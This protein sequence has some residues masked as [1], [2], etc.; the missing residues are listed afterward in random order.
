[1]QICVMVQALTGIL[2]PVTYGP[3]TMRGSSCLP[4]TKSQTGQMMACFTCP[5][6]GATLGSHTA[7]GEHVRPCDC[8]TIFTDRL[9]L[10]PRQTQHAAGRGM[11]LLRIAP[12]TQAT[13]F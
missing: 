12:S 4:T 1:M 5:S 8:L 2:T 11:G 6:R 3:L 9:L 13:L 10:Q 7:I